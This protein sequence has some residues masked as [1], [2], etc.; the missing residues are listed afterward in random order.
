M[1]Y[2]IKKLKKINVNYIFVYLNDP[3]EDANEPFERKDFFFSGIAASTLKL[4]ALAILKLLINW[5]FDSGTECFDFSCVPEGWV[6][7]SGWLEYEYET[8]FNIS[9]KIYNNYN[10]KF[11]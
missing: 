8:I 3:K 6:P 9:R 10:N 4:L 11:Q 1:K 7:F 2:Y 5:L